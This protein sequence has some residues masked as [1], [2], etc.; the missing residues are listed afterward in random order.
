LPVEQS[1]EQSKNIQEDPGKTID[2]SVSVVVAEPVRPT[3]SNILG[4]IFNMNNVS[5]SESPLIK[6]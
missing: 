3:S 5:T 1:V 6:V 2:G 4:D